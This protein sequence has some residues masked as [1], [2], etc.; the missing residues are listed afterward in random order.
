VKQNHEVMDHTFNDRSNIF[1]NQ[2]YSMRNWNL[3]RRGGCNYN[4]NMTQ[5]LTVPIYVTFLTALAAV[6]ITG[7]HMMWYNLMNFV[8]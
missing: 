5:S 6:I 2:V 3:W 4:A 8:K 1:D 7:I